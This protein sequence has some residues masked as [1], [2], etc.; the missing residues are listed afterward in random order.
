MVIL[1]SILSLG[2]VIFIVKKHWVSRRRH[3]VALGKLPGL[4]SKDFRDVHGGGLWWNAMGKAILIP[5]NEQLNT[6]CGRKEAI[7]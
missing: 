3:R 1:N 7:A 4:L 2:I 5:N 6:E